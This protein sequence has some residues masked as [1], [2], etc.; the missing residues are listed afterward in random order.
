LGRQEV[1]NCRKREATKEPTGKSRHWHPA[2][3]QN[4]NNKSCSP[5]H[6]SRRSDTSR[7]GGQANARSSKRSS[8]ATQRSVDPCLR[9]QRAG[10]LGYCTPRGQRANAD[11]ED[12]L[13][14]KLW[15]LRIWLVLDDQFLKKGGEGNMKKIDK[16]YQKPKVVGKT[17][18]ASM[19]GAGCPSHTVQWQQVSCK[20]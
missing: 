2:C 3:W 10:R 15:R 14:P 9:G 19:S 6:T 11:L 20:C 17:K 7:P 5:V 8:L 16:P 4:P 1:R 18:K 13:S 12:A